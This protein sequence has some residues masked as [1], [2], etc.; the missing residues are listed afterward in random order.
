MGTLGVVGEWLA[1]PYLVC[2]NI[3][4]FVVTSHKPA[5]GGNAKCMRDLALGDVVDG[6]IDA[7]DY[8]ELKMMV[9]IIE[10]IG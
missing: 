3:L 2:P 9:K 8:N 7:T 10:R 5:A 4:F 6:L 1:T